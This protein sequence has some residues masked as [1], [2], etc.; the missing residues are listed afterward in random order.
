METWEALLIFAVSIWLVLIEIPRQIL[1]LTRRNRELR[2]Q[3]RRIMLAD[4]VEYW[5]SLDN[6]NRSLL[7]WHEENAGEETPFV[8][9][10][11]IDS[12]IERKKAR[13]RFTKQDFRIDIANWVKERD[14]IWDEMIKDEEDLKRERT[15][16]RARKQDSLEKK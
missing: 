2:D 13:S 10:R 9:L 15:T 4:C 6:E 3:E 1:K 8:D 16:R 7:K 5:E 14:R 11:E 12:K